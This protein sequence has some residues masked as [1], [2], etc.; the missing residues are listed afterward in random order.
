MLDQQ[1]PTREMRPVSEDPP[2]RDH[3]HIRV[4][5]LGA[6]TYVILLGWLLYASTARLIITLDE[7]VIDWRPITG[8]LIALL[9][10]TALHFGTEHDPW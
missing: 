7:G 4:N 5:F 2:K 1:P 8:M 10:L 9:G 6:I 3:W